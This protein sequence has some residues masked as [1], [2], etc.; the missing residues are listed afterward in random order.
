MP[1][2][3][4]G[5]SRSR[6]GR[7]AQ[8]RRP[9]T[10]D[11]F[12]TYNALGEKTGFTD[13][14]GTI[15]AYTIDVLGRMTADAVTHFASG[16]DNAITSLGYSF[17]GAGR[18][19]QQTSYNS[20][21]VKN[22]QEMLYDGFGE[23]TNLYQDHSKAV[24]TTPGSA[25]PDVVYAY[26]YGTNTAG[27]S[28]SR[29]TRMTYPG[30]RAITDNYNTA[31]PVL[32]S[33]DSSISRLSYLADG[34]THLEEYSYLGLGTIVIRNRP[35][36]HTQLTYY[37]SG[38]SGDGGDQ[39]V[40]LDRFGR[41]V[42]QNW[43][44]SSTG[45]ST[46]R[47]QYGYDPDN[48]VLYRLNAGPGTNAAKNS[49][50]YHAAGSGNGYDNLNRLVEFTRGTLNGTNDSITGTAARD[51]TFTLDGVGNWNTLVSSTNGTSTTQTRSANAENQYSTISGGGGHTPLY[52]SDGNTTKNELGNAFR[53]DAWNRMVSVTDT[54]GF[55]TIENMTYLPGD[56][57]S[58]SDLCHA[59]VTDSYYSISQQVVEDDAVQTI[60]CGGC[61][62]QTTTTSTYAWGEDYVND[63]IER[64][65]SSTRVYAQHDA[66]WDITSLVNANSS[67]GVLER[68]EYDPY[69]TRTVLNASTWAATT[70]SQAWVYS[71]QGGRLDPIS[72]LIHFGARDLSTTLG[73]WMQEDQGYG[74]GMNLYEALGSSPIG[75][76]DPFG[77]EWHITRD[78][79][80][81]A[82]A[83]SDCKSD[84]IADLAGP[85]GQRLTIDNVAIQC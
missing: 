39:Y 58:A 25:S 36:N 46:D 16:I 44:N 78:G 26:G 18:P 3:P 9:A 76:V 84:T 67:P 10:N 64:D 69:G 14:N 82:L 72:G 17:D 7:K 1:N 21:T 24:V 23:L 13:Q 27:E 51:Q 43:I 50:L 45:V 85:R 81:R 62:F 4:A 31:D 20:A 55:A 12:F 49:E 71:F 59:T 68:F 74:K 38:G 19:F 54:F 57:A 61:C 40:G 65:Q 79:Q 22:Q 33:L 60:N 47:F 63:L 8:R 77:D 41:I 56:T 48:N 32:G 52:D 66:N 11:Q 15:H 2:E 53:F 70:D 5:R 28:Y 29:Q 73:R 35:S 6:S 80:R 34:N 83:E 37:L 75:R 30:G 42:D